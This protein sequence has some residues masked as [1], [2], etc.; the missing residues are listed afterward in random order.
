MP[1]FF[2]DFIYENSIKMKNKPDLALLGTPYRSNEIKKEHQN[3]MRL[4]L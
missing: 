2:K 4:S 1:N 3:I